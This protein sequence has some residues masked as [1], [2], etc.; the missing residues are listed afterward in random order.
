MIAVVFL[1]VMG[2]FAF[3]FSIWLAGLLGI[4]NK[5]KT[6]HENIYEPGPIKTTILKMKETFR[7]D[8]ANPT[9][10]CR[11]NKH[12]IPLYYND[13]NPAN[14]YQCVTCKNIITITVS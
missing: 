3:F 11:C 1:F 8:S 12:M 10:C 14:Q 7:E 6:Q 2:V 9:Y 13:G 4:T 5:N